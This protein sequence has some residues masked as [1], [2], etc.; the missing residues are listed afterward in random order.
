[1]KRF[2]LIL[3]V[4]MLV[5]TNAWAL[6]KPI[7]EVR[8][9]N[10]TTSGVV[11]TGTIGYSTLYRGNYNF[12][13]EGSGSHPG[14]DIPCGL[15]TTVYNIANGEVA[16]ADSIDNS[17]WGK[18]V[19]VRHDI[20]PAGVVYSCYAHLDS[21]NV[22]DEQQIDEGDI[23]GLSGNTGESTG[24]H[25][26]FQ[27]DRYL[28]L[29][30]GTIITQDK[31]SPYW[32]SWGDVNQSDPHHVVELYTINPM[33]FLQMNQ[34]APCFVPVGFV[35]DTNNPGRYYWQNGSGGDPLTGVSQEFRD[36]YDAFLDST[37]T[38]LGFPWRNTEHGDEGVHQLTPNIQAQDFYGP[39][40]GL[41]LAWS[42]LVYGDQ[43]E[44]HLLKEGF[45]AKWINSVGW[46]TVGA[47]INE[48]STDCLFGESGDVCQTFAKSDTLF[49]FNW[50]TEDNVI[51]RDENGNIVDLAQIVASWNGGSSSRDPNDGVYHSGVKI[52]NFSQAFHLIN[53]QSYDG[54]YAMVDDQP[55][56]IEAFTVNGDMTINIGG[57]AIVPCVIGSTGL[58]FQAA[59]DVNGQYAYLGNE[60]GIV[61]IIDISD[62][63][64][65]E[66]VGSVNCQDRIWDITLDSGYLY[67][68]CGA[69]EF[70]SLK[71]VDVSDP[72]HPQIVGSL[73]GEETSHAVAIS[74]GYAYVADGYGGLRIIDISEPSSPVLV[75][76][77]QDFSEFLNVALSGN[78]AYVT[79][80]EKVNIIDISQPNT[81]E[82]VNYVPAPPILS[83][84]IVSDYAY[85][86]N[87]YSLM[88]A[89]ISE[90]TNF[91]FISGLDLLPPTESIVVYNSRAYITGNGFGLQIV[92]VANPATPWLVGEMESTGG[93]Y[94]HTYQ[95]E[96]FGDYAYIA[97][98]L[99]L[100]VARLHCTGETPAEDLPSPIH[101]T[102]DIYPNPFNPE[103]HIAFSLAK[104]QAVRLAIYDVA[105]RQVA[106]L[107][108]RVWEAGNHSLEWRGRD[109]AD[110]L[111]STG[112]YLIRLETPDQT[113]TSKAVL[114]K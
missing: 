61:Q 8:D 31:T 14:V 74:N 67:V 87:E 53:G 19:I 22:I 15:R 106:I 51:V 24:Y 60:S 25:L 29:D 6:R 104:T 89:D 42:A 62:P 57:P 96:A 100:V 84:Q 48:E 113:L 94:T 82:I 114:L 32:P 80:Q 81:A 50:N 40:N 90:P 103:V 75:H 2:F 58:Q 73:A 56:E 13:N 44:V 33:P 98:D 72:L 4:L 63:P 77:V 102:L 64:T 54:F 7:N 17:G 36:V 110:R 112:V 108:D 79:T 35:K 43:D 55:L 95:I 52:A 41:D 9:Y 71:I 66:V 88:V 5:S 76:V 23:I 27:I 20:N 93:E 47:P 3:T 28:K 91:H 70:D 11:N 46:V 86:L 26:H 34:Y 37:D 1:M 105:G 111:V 83:L 21:V 16:I 59:I 69:A 99:G 85:L 97:D 49:Y 38:V 107:A 92:D 101:Q 45:W 12:G 65:P 39:H 18:Y 78:Y 10:G 68:C 30:D 109:S